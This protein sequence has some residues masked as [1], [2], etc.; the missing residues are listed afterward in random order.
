MR[1]EANPCHGWPADD[2]HIEIPALSPQF[3]FAPFVF[4]LSPNSDTILGQST[5][6]A[7]SVIDLDI[8]T[9]A[10][11]SLQ[12]VYDE[13]DVVSLDQ[14]DGPLGQTGQQISAVLPRESNL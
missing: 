1:N 13:G 5:P 9:N 12:I 2:N 11:Q 10:F 6:A 8:G 4:S 14:Q 3:R 7:L